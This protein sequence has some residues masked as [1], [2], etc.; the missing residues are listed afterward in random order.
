MPLETQKL[1]PAIG[2]AAGE[3][4]GFRRGS[5][6]FLFRVND[7]NADQLAFQ[8]RLLPDRG[9]A[10]EL[11]NSWRERFFTFDTLPVPDGRY[12][13]E[14][15]ASDAPTQPFN[16]ALSAVWR[17]AAFMVDHTP[18]VISE[19]SATQEGEG[20]RIRFAAKDESSLLKE[21]ALSANGDTWL[22][23]AP[24]DRVFDRKEE[25]FDILVPREHVKGDRVLV[26]IVDASSNEQSAAVM[27]GV[28]SGRKK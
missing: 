26:R 23:I 9:R 17:T 16:G 25:H 27:I 12:R 8:I 15:V 11:E 2:L 10:I 5:Q 19:L 24:E 3:K 6:A 28:V 4:R 1:I 21:A 18:P 13:L 14:V 7:P 22:Q 20:V